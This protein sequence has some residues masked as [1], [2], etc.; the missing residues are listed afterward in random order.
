M[1]P[2]SSRYP[3]PP[4]LL[5][6]LGV[7]AG[8][9]FCELMVPASLSSPE[10]LRWSAVLLGLGIAVG[11][12]FAAIRRPESL[13]HPISV[14]LLALLYWVLLDLVQALYIPEVRDV[15]AV[16]AAFYAIA[17]FAI[18]V[19]LAVR[20][21]VV[22]LPAILVATAQRSLSARSIFILGILAFLVAFLRFAIPSEFDPVRMYNALFLSRWAAPWARGAYGG[23]DAFLD[24]LAY[25]G[26]LLP[27]LTILLLRAECRVTPRSMLLSLLA[28]IIM[29]LLAQGGGRR[30]VG[31]LAASAGVAWVLTAKRKGKALIAISLLGVPALLFYLQYILFTRAH[32]IGG[33]EHVSVHALMSGGLYVDD[34]FNR[35]AQIIEIVPASVPHVG[36]NW[37]IWIAVRPIPRVL[38]PSK[39]DNMGF[40]LADYL[41]M[42]G[43]SL[44]TSI[45]GESYLAFG[46]IGCFL[47]GLVYGYA[48]RWLTTL[49]NYRANAG[50]VLLIALGLLALF[51]GVRS[52]I[53]A[54]LFSYAILAWIVLSHLIAPASRKSTP[55]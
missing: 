11:P 36:L 31:A 32:G 9:A 12:L 45:V 49:L 16:R 35:L 55:R 50:A 39:P 29:L 46:F 48:G 25:F 54:V 24:H 34:N 20:L 44:S 42:H 21:P 5:S 4:I 8:L 17:L 18:G 28:F 1:K 30:I 2:S 7:I 10:D 22:P 14:L 53:E 15:G 52:A 6:I 3:G 27:V 37:L 38:W 19:C 47:T 23:W 33:S 43:V 51:V 13:L 26:Y 40:D 41:G